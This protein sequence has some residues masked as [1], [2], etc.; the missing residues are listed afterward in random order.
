LTKLLIIHNYEAPRTRKKTPNS[1]CYYSKGLSQIEVSTEMR[2]IV[3]H[4]CQKPCACVG[5][6]YSGR[7][8]RCRV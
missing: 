6:Q 4:N 1:I 5:A 3:Y 2:R 7:S 8:H